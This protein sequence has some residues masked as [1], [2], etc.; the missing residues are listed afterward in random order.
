MKV[1]VVSA[2]FPPEPMVSARTSAQIAAHLA[3][4]GHKVQVLAPF[5]NRPGGMLYPGHRRRLFARQQHSDGYELTYCFSTLAPQSS[6]RQRFAE[7]ISFGLTSSLA[8]LFSTRPDVIYSNSW[9]IFATGL[10]WLVARLRGIPL[11]ISV[12]DVYPES[13]TAQGRPAQGTLLR[14]MR[15]LDSLIART[16]HHLVVISQ[17][18]ADLYRADRG[19][20]PQRISVVPNWAES[21]SIDLATDQQTWRR[22]RGIGDNHFVLAYGGNI[23]VAAGVETVIE[24]LAQLPHLPDLRLLIAG[25]GSRLQACRDLADQQ[26]ER[27]VLFH[28]PWALAETSAVLRAADV[29]VL[30]TRGNQSIASVP[31][32][33]ISYLLAARPVIALV[34]PESEIAHIINESGGGW[35]IPPDRP[36]LLAEKISTVARLDAAT[37]THMGQAGRI[38]ALQHLTREV[39]LPRLVNIILSAGSK[40]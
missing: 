16:A 34:L 21:D 35:V 18:F 15:R 36:D 39:C 14:T 8:T 12:Q 24:A 30:P 9:P 2:V 3:G 1:L 10:I 33:L 11:V 19:V 26:D 27:R 37:R 28:T 17:H 13:L 5:P 22:E 40:S 7:N 29:L 32:K 38:Y 25:E 20:P 6:L 4:D 23:G 31:S